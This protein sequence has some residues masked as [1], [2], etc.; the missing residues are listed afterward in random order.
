[1]LRF[2]RV[3]S[4]IFVAAALAVFATPA[5]TAYAA[6]WLPPV[7]GGSVIL[8]FGEAYPGGTHR[9]V[10]I[11]ATSGVMVSAPVAGTVSFAGRVPAD[12]GGTCV[13]VTLELA[14]GRRMSLLPLG[15]AGVESG[16]CVEAGQILGVLAASGDDS[17]SATHL[18]VSLRRGE[19]YLDPGDLV[20]Q[21]AA[22]TT[23]QPMAPACPP[24]ALPDDTG[25]EPSAAAASV[26]AASSCVGVV[27]PDSAQC[28]TAVPSIAAGSVAAIHRV[29]SRPEN[30]NAGV[31]QASALMPS[32]WRGTTRDVPVL[33]PLDSRVATGAG[34]ACAMIATGGG[35]VLSRRAQ[36]VRVD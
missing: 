18:H 12:G 30:E 36:P 28:G 7:E 25:G 35:I 32:G 15:S 34:L 27:S 29:A 8:G 3:R 6:E 20:S 19:L 17:S 4:L 26:A 2:R 5:S 1:M 31:P 22:V 10:D 23:A 13:A 9:G 33:A 14:D 16:E 11:A 21:A 24:S